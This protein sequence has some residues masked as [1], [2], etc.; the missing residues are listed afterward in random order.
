MLPCGEYIQF[1]KQEQKE[2]KN[3]FGQNEFVE[4]FEEYEDKNNFNSS[5]QQTQG[6]IMNNNNATKEVSFQVKR[7]LFKNLVFEKQ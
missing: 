3:K 7:P 5:K 2:H 4:S 1:K 6:D